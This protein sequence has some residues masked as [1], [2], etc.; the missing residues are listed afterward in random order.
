MY[1]TQPMPPSDSAT[2]RRGKR[3][4]T[5]ESNRSAVVYMELQPNNE[6]LT[7]NGASGEVAGAFP[8][9]PKCMHS[10]MSASWAAAKTASQPWPWNDGS[11]SGNGL[12]GNEM[13][14]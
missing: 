9:V 8:D 3:W 11:P 6:M 14:L 12:S 5:G 2:L 13:A 10:G 7:A 1:G 4:N